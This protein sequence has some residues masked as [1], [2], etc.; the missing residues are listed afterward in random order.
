MIGSS[1]KV[2]IEAGRQGSAA[3][4]ELSEKLESPLDEVLVELE[5]PAVP[6]VGIEE[7]VAVGESLSEVDGVL[8]RHHLVALTVHGEHGLVH[9]REVRR[10]LLTP[11][12]DGLELG[13]EGAD[14]DGLVAVAGPFLQPGQ[15]LLAGSAPVR[16]PGEEEELL[17][18]LGGGG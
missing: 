13:A 10:L 11:S 8:G 18:G 12:V 2:R 9:A 3:A 1:P 14:G 6:G 17:G 4:R 15:E 7:E 5:D 16:G